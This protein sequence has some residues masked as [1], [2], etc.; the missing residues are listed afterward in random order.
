[1]FNGTP[2]ANLSGDALAF[3]PVCDARLREVSQP[4]TNLARLLLLLRLSRP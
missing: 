4:G 1:M 3:G 2:F